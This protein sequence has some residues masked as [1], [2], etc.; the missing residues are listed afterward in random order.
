M[1]GKRL[2]VGLRAAPAIVTVALLVTSVWAA[3][4]EKVLHNF[5]NGTDGGN[6]LAGLISDA[7]GNFYGTTENGGVYGFGTVFELSPKPGGGWTE[8]VRY[9]FN[10]NSQA[11]GTPVGGLIFDATGKS[12]YGTTSSGGAYCCGTVFELTP[13]RAGRWMEKVLHSFNSQDGANPNASLIFD[14]SGSLYGTTVFG[15]IVTGY[16]RP[17]GCGTVFELMPEKGGGWREKLLHKF[18]SSDGAG[19]SADLIFDTAGNLYGTSGGGPHGGGTVFK[20]TPLADGGWRE[21]VLHGFSN[22]GRDGIFPFAGVISDAA[23]NLYGTTVYG[24]SGTC[25]PGCGTVFEL[26]PRAGGGWTEKVLYSFKNDGKDGI[27]PLAGLVFDARKANLYGTTRYGG[28]GVCDNGSG[29]SG[30]GTVFELSPKAGGGWTEKVL[31]S[32]ENNGKDG[33]YPF[34]DLIL[35]G[36]HN[37]YGTAADGGASGTGCGGRG[38]G[39]VFEITP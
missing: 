5:G 10:A 20:L 1:R 7:A 30:C 11:G 36:Q 39:T 26:V 8:K 27:G 25:S 37:L 23:G 35:D 9:D 38:C 21:K 2:S 31:F 22:N 14:G 13:G 33:Y 12:L 28:T 18:T 4:R 29:V 16:C 3:P 32:F 19:P 6:P 24:G 34:A 15:G 17:N